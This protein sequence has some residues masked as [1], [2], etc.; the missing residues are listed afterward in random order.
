MLDGDIVV[1]AGLTPCIPDEFMELV[2]VAVPML[3]TVAYKWIH[4]RL[5]VGVPDPRRIRLAR[6]QTGPVHVVLVDV[7][8]RVIA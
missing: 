6:P 7:V 1:D 3:V 2:L 8:R 5:D 4:Q